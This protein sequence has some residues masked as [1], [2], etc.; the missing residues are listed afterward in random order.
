MTDNALVP[1]RQDT[2]KLQR[3]PNGQFADG[4]AGNP[5]GSAT[6]ERK[7]LNQATI[8]ELMIAFNR[9]GAQAINKVMR[10]NPAMFLKM[11]VLLVPRELQIEHSGGIKA[12]T[13]EQIE[14]SIEFIKEQLARRAAGEDAKVIEHSPTPAK[15]AKPAKVGAL[16]SHILSQAK[17]T[18]KPRTTITKAGIDKDNP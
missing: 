14:R 5:L 18:R 9:G 12:M 17:R 4:H 2:Q 15:P 7:A 10:N 1:H 8:R 3:H 16:S 6:R 11:L 13:D